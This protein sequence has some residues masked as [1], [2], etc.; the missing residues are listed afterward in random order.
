MNLPDGQLERIEVVLTVALLVVVATAIP[1]LLRMLRRGAVGLSPRQ[2][3][4]AAMGATVAVALRFV[5]PGRMVMMY[6][7]FGL[8][9]TAIQLRGL[10]RWGATATVV[11]HLALQVLPADHA[12]ILALHGA[13]GSI[14]TVL[15]A[16]WIARLS[17]DNQAG[18]WALWLGAATPLLVHDHRTESILVVA[19]ALLWA[20]LLLLDRF[21]ASGRR[22]TL[23]AGTAALVLAATTRPEL[24]LIV[25]AFVGVAVWLRRGELTRAR[26][27]VLGAAALLGVSCAVPHGAHVL[28]ST[29][30]EL[31]RGSLP[32]LDGGLPLRVLGGWFTEN[33]LVRPSLFPLGALVLALFATFGSHRRLSLALW[34]LALLWLAT[35]FVDLPE[36]SIPRLHAPAAHLVA[37]NAA[38]AAA[39]IPARAAQ[40]WSRAGRQ[41][42]VVGLALALMASAAPT[43]RHLWAWTNEDSQEVV[44]RRAASLLPSG[45]CLVR[46]GRTDLQPDE[47]TH[48]H[49]PDYLVERTRPRV[50]VLPVGRRHSARC[51]GGRYFL[52]DLRCYA[53]HEDGITR[54]NR[55]ISSRC[56]LGPRC[57]EASF[58]HRGWRRPARPGLRAPCAAAMREVIG[59]PVF[60]TTVAS[61][62]DNE[63]GY[64]PPI[65]A[66]RVGLFPLAQQ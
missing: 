28:N 21:I 51:D 55:E 13:I 1:A 61:V 48:V 62:G 30:I 36:Q 31:G 45:A 66:F 58:R 47:R 17:R 23:V 27:R 26:C 16:L 29:W 11:H 5:A 65:A 59:T 7:G 37:L 42:A 39:W 20:G 56:W 19:C 57:H 8:T 46:L 40:R 33:A 35:S 24:P 63:F 38:L 14:T 44:A 53:R 3:R 15:A 34:S 6:V 10:P 60:D 54:T 50:R 25:A 49:F 64:Y 12:S 52:L 4:L 2:R 43:L 22:A 32:S 18:L 9:D 41:A